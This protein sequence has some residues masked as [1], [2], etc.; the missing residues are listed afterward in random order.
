MASRVRRLL[1]AAAI[2]ALLAGLTAGAT[3]ASAASSEAEGIAEGT[4]PPSAVED[5]GYPGAAKLLQEKKL[6]L[7]KGD[8]HILLA[9]C[10][11]S[12]QQIKVWNRNGDVC[13]Q[14]NAK[15]GYL[16]MEIPKVWALET[17][18]HPITA[19]LTANGKTESVDV[20]KGGWK[21]VGEGTPDGT[22]SV[23]VEI[24]VTG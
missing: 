12:P 16:T 21:S 9:E 20:P 7:I 5:F 18:S 10:G 17:A 15:S 14:V 24:R 8:G 1:L 23:L 11:D 19:D 22:R 4:R 2:P 13:F 3:L 6:K